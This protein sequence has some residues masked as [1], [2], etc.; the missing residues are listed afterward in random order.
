[1]YKYLLLTCSVFLLAPALYGDADFCEEDKPCD[2]EEIVFSCPYC[3]SYLYYGCDYFGDNELD[4]LKSVA[5]WPSRNDDPF[6]QAL[7]R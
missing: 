7:S 3:K 1:V 2:D 4:A 5:T 6:V